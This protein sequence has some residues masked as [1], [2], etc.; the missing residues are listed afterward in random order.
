MYILK[1][2]ESDFAK[3]QLGWIAV[4]LYKTQVVYRDLYDSTCHCENIVSFWSVI[5]TTCTSS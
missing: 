1:H 5:V 3:F 4:N 2:K